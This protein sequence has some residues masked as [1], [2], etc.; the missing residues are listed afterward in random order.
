[1][2]ARSLFEAAVA[3]HRN[4]QLADAAAGYRKVLTTDPADLGALGNLALVLSSL[5]RHDDAQRCMRAAV[6]LKP[7]DA[8]SWF[9]LANLQRRG[10][11]PAE[12]AAIYRRT[13][14]L[15][16]GMAGAW[17][18]CSV[19]LI[20]AREP[21]EA[22]LAARRAV[23][24]APA[25]MNAHM[26]VSQALR[27]QVRLA[28]AAA[29]ARNVLCVDPANLQGWHMLASLARGRGAFRLA[30]DLLG[31]V[32]R[33]APD[34]APLESLRLFTMAADPMASPVDVATA[35]RLWGR[36]VSASP[37]ARP[38]ARRPSGADG[39]LRVGYVS[40][41]L[42]RHSVAHFLLP[43]LASHDRDRF[44]VHLYSETA[45]SDDV[46]AR[47]RQQADRWLDTAGFDAD[48][49][50][51]RVA[52]DRL[53][54]LIDCAGHTWGNRLD[55]FARRPA[56]VQ[57]TWLGYPH[58]TGLPAIDYRIVDGITD[59]PGSE[60]LSTERLL[61]LDPC[62]LCYAPLDPPPPA[63]RGPGPLTFASF[64][65][66]Y[67]LGDDTIAA[68]SRILRAV[69]AA[70]LLLKSRALEDPGQCSELAARFAAAGL[71]GDRLEMIGWTPTQNEHQRLYH[72]VDIALDSFPYNGTTTTCDA[73]WMG[74]PVVTL[75]GESHIARV[76]ASLLR[77]AGLDDLVAAD[78]D[79]YCARA[80][81]LAAAPERLRQLR[82]SLRPRLEAS[83]L[84]DARAFAR[85]FET[86]IR[87]MLADPQP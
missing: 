46:T 57:A 27:G 67:K 61:R 9:N 28:A 49:L 31:R 23:R 55:L 87:A 16:P 40:A 5:A 56:R 19:A 48:R 75:R 6:R 14:E 25:A 50:A 29:T 22:E 81:A 33:L 84:G 47:F 43:L 52:E 60:A 53:D 58:S 24:L 26:A 80:I 45:K 85:R 68:W 2:A 35:H 18:N 86:G 63:L 17:L 37:V 15:A 82:A 20:E 42:Y 44:A 3:A 66:A 41:D 11:A 21:A 8:A 62:F 54:L 73:L 70:R 69:P 65:D 83:A 4:G 12:A 71:A 32:L 30:I 76:G 78:Q 59:P 79:D 36:R 51:A 7:D 10:G 74:V 1:M 64:N 13:L 72:R 77:Q 39:R 38:T 34:N